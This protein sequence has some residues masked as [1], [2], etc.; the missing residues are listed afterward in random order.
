MTTPELPE[1]GNHLDEVVEYLT[2]VWPEDVQLQLYE[3]T[4][5]AILDSEHMN[6][7]EGFWKPT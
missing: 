5:I 2:T 3:D 4:A 1:V 7:P 6:Y